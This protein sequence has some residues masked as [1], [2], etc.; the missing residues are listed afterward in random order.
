MTTSLAHRGPDDFGY[1]FQRD[2]GLALGHRRLSIVD[3][4][5]AGHQP[6]GSA[7]GRYQIALNGEIYNH[8]A[9][10]A[11]LEGSGAAPA[12]HGHSDTEVLLAAIEAWGLQGALQRSVGMFALALWDRTHRRLSL[13]RDR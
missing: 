10:R 5:P 9:L 11:Q 12:W 7:T 13:A 6:M 1:W 8:V 4:S 2:V 3:L